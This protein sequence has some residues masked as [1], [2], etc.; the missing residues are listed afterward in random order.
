MI[1]RPLILLA[2][3]AAILGA[4]P[5]AA[6]AAE[7]P[8]TWDNLVQVKA[9]NLQAVYLLPGADFRAYTKIM[10]DPTEVDF[11]KGWV[12]QINQNYGFA[13]GRT[14]DADAAAIA[15]QVRIGFDQIFAK[16]FTKAGYQVVTEPGPDVLRLSTAVFN[17]F[18]T[19][20]RSVTMSPGVN[21]RTVDAGSASVLIQVRDSETGQVLGRALDVRTAGATDNYLPRTPSGNQ[22]DFGILFDRWADISVKGL[23]KLKAMSPVDPTGQPAKPAP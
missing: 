1:R 21:V 17:L 4:A 10:L 15:K 18:I 9:K 23:E 3:T 16:A 13:Y 11:V 8:T 2:A 22:A 12:K 19:A 14:D 6:Q 7:M 5:I 20:P